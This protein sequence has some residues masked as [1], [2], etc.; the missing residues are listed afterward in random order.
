[1]ISGGGGEGK[2]SLCVCGACVR[3]CACVRGYVVRGRGLG[4]ENERSAHFSRQA[5]SSRVSERAHPRDV[6]KAT[7]GLPSPHD[8]YQKVRFDAGDDVR[9]VIEPRLLV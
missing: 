8:K 5:E 4:E 9:G 3:M 6:R 1:M 7:K 2:L